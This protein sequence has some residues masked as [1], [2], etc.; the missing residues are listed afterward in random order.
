M[1]WKSG[2]SG[3]EKCGGR[4]KE[5]SSVG[6]HISVWFAVVVAGTASVANFMAFTNTITLAS[7]PGFSFLCRE[8]MF[9][10][11]YKINKYNN[12]YN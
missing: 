4:R 1:G 7:L 6:K 9:P 11:N 8:K 10:Y 3:R 5:V 12:K 2:A